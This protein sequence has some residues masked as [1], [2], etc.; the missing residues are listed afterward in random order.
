MFASTLH[1]DLMKSHQRE[2][3][4]AAAIKG[5]HEYP[6]AKPAEPSR[7]RRQRVFFLRSLSRV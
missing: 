1:A 6:T 2:L 3:A 7:P 5:P 4:A